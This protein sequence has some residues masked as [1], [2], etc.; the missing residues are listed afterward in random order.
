[1]ARLWS[2]L[3]PVLYPVHFYPFTCLPAVRIAL[4]HP[5]TTGSCTYSLIYRCPC[6]SVPASLGSAVR[7]SERGGDACRRRW[8]CC[9]ARSPSGGRPIGLTRHT[10]CLSAIILSI[11]KPQRAAATV[12]ATAVPRA[13]AACRN[14]EHPH[15]LRQSVSGD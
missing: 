3:E 5:L 11:L 6:R 7:R 2:L 14:G 9:G 4:Q 12:A 10:F 13:Q 1:M 15:V 8:A